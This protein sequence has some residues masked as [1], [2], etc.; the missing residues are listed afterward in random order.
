MWMIGE[1]IVEKRAARVTVVV[2]WSTED[3][4]SGIWY[5]KDDEVVHYATGKVYELHYAYSNGRRCTNC[6]RSALT[7][8]VV[9]DLRLIFQTL[10]MRRTKTTVCQ[11][12]YSWSL[13]G[14]GVWRVMSRVVKHSTYLNHQA[15]PIEPDHLTGRRA[16]AYSQG[17]WG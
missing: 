4:R 9:R 10:K 16:A 8:G 14:V 11:R 7:S 15:N 13:E 12:G 17:L 6:M 3:R 2:R 1:I 5:T